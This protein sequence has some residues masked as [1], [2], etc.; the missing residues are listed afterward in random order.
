MG[1]RPPFAQME[2]MYRLRI[3]PEG[4]PIPTEI[5]TLHRATEVLTT[6]PEL[7]RRHRNCQRIEVCAGTT[8]LFAVDGKGRLL[9]QDA[10]AQ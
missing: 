2:A 8:A 10:P 1:K 7:L 9:D 4:T 6:I 5:V 3:I